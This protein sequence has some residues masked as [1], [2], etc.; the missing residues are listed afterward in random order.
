MT[1]FDERVEQIESAEKDVDK[2]LK[3]AKLQRNPQG[4]D[5]W[6]YRLK[7]EFV[8]NMTALVLITFS[9]AGAIIAFI[10]TH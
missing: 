8:F 7:S 6:E 10:V 3:A 2:V 5:R 9:I 1:T 4:F